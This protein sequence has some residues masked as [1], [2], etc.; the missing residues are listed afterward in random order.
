MALVRYYHLQHPVVVFDANKLYR[1]GCPI[2]FHYHLDMYHDIL[3][4]L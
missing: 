4:A 1:L 3:D 2:S